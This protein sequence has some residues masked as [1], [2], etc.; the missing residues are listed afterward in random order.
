MKL[1]K[2]IFKNVMELEGCIEFPEGK[3][4]VIYGENKAGKSNII[5]ALRYAFLSKVVRPRKTSGYDELRLVTTKEIAPPQDVGKILIEFSHDGQQ[6]QIHREIDRYRDD[7]K[8][9]RKEADGFREL[10]FAKTLDKELKAGLLDALFAPDSAMGFNHLNEK[11]IDAVIRELFKEIGN[12]KVLTKDFKQRIQRLKEETSAR[13]TGIE[14]DYDSFVAWLKDELRD[15]RLDL[16]EFD[17]YEVGKTSENISNLTDKLKGHIDSLEKGELKEWMGEMRRRAKDAED[18]EGLLTDSYLLTA[19]SFQ[20]IKQISQDRESLNVLVAALREARLGGPM[21][22]EPG[23]LHDVELDNKVRTLYQKLK[24]AQTRYSHA[25]ALAQEEKIDFKIDNPARIKS[26]KEKVLNLLTKEVLTADAPRVKVDLVKIRS[27]PKLRAEGGTSSEETVHGLV[28]LKLMD[29]DPAFARLSP[30]PIPDAPEEDKKKY[31]QLLAKRVENLRII[32]EDKDSAESFFDNQFVP[33]LTR[34]SAYSTT[35]MENE[36]TEK[37]KISNSAK[38][39]HNKLLLFAREHIDMPKLER[40]EDSKP[41]LLAVRQIMSGKKSAYG[42]EV[43]QRAKSLGIQIAEF[44]TQEI[45]SL[46]W[47]L[48]EME[49]GVPYYKSI[50]TQLTKQKRIEWGNNDAEYADLTYVPAVVDGI[51]KTLAT[52][53]DNAFDEQEIIEGIQEIIVEINNKLMA[54]GLVNSC[55]EMGEGS[56]Q[57]SKTT[58][59]DK[60][61]THP[62]G[63]ERSFFSLATLSALARYFRLPV[64]IDEAANNLDKNHL[65]HF[66]SLIREFA[67]SY[68]VQYILSIKETD[69]FPLGGWVQEFADDLQIYRVDYDGHRKRITPVDLYA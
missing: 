18:L 20:K 13:V 55:I 10:D 34:I 31:A 19:D 57:L 11:N 2:L 16:S 22:P 5:H 51:D 45:D 27:G 44:N 3:T 47:K 54:E 35:L 12:A 30:E 68:D 61:I 17:T 56:L 50:W 4:V 59:K 6:F 46:L 64:I 58:Y 48:A 7:N 67:A 37:E 40:Q 9:L 15:L 25:L 63:A 28:P 41:F 49:K 38:D 26:D 60:E 23:K 43:N 52:I 14:R 39:I 1:S 53:L 66:V 65:R 29:E 8:I 32:C 24:D 33:E 69:D 62:C 21:P 36:K 42:E